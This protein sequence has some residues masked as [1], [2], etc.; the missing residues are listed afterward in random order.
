MATIGHTLV[1][2]S[3]AGLS[4][5]ESRGHAMRYLWPG[6]M[7][8]MG[9]LVDV[10]EWFTIVLFPTWA[11]G[12]Y[13]TH[14]PLATCAFVVLICLG[15][16]IIT[17]LRKP[18]P[19]VLIAVAIVSHLALDALWGR[20]ALA[21]MYG[22][23]PDDEGYP[24]RQT[25]VA[26][27]WLY[28]LLLLL[29]L[30]GRAATEKGCPRFG[31]AAAWVLAGLAILAAASRI[32]VVWFPIYA[33]GFFHATIL[34]RRRF[35]WGLLWGLVPLIPLGACVAAEIHSSNMLHRAWD[36]LLEKDYR[37]SLA[38]YQQAL[39]F[40]M[41]V[42]PSMAYVHIAQ[43]HDY[44]GELP[45]AEKYFKKAADS[46]DESGWGH[47]WL[48]WF[49]AK[50]DWRD[51]PYYRPQEAARILEQLVHDTDRPRVKKVAGNLLADVKSRPE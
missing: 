42:S 10:L 17:R 31:R 12:H 6:F 24:L 3:C 48:A 30:L 18:W 28:G 1:G 26:E 20:R 40:P 21:D 35:H 11:S 50:R 25:I 15:V 49:Y 34:L 22:V 19:Y 32:A 39:C 16:L 27:V 2:L 45:D 41:R 36:R 13:L 33:L 9:H 44:M 23:A 29:V 37:G 43:C 5:E 4:R 47:Y 7:I 51:T 8:L 46:S 14:S 38:L